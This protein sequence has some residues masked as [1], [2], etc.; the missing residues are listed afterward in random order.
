MSKVT[1]WNTLSRIQ[2][3]MLMCMLVKYV[4]M[5]IMCLLHKQLYFYNC[6][7]YTVL[8]WVKCTLWDKGLLCL[9]FHDLLLATSSSEG[10][11]LQEVL[12][13]PQYSVV[14]DLNLLQYSSI[15][16]NLDGNGY[17]LLVEIICSWTSDYRHK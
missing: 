13:L 1:V 9:Y 8:S 12:K 15:F 10:T 11:F 7:Y 6:T 16:R 3:I 5:Y 17:L 2:I 14:A 4:N